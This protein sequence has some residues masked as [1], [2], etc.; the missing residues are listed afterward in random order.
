MLY[1]WGSIYVSY[2][3]KLSRCKSTCLMVFFITELGG[4]ESTLYLNDR[5][6]H[7][8]ASRLGMEQNKHN[9][10]DLGVSLANLGNMKIV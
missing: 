2:F 10:N 5:I 6:R 3:D 4:M 7:L 1:L 9:T 8:G